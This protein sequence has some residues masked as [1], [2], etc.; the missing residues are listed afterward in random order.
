MPQRVKVNEIKN[1]YALYTKPRWEK[2]VYQKLLEKQIE[3]YCP[4]QKQTRQWSDR[5]KI[6]EEPLFKSYVFVLADEEDIP[7][8]RM[9]PGVVNFVYW[10]GKPAIVNKLDI[11]RIQRFLNEHHDIALAPMH[12]VIGQGD[13]VVIMGG[14]FMDKEAIVM[15][16]GA[17]KVELLIDSLGCKLIAWVDIEKIQR[18]R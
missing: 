1:W 6:V 18:L 11:E 14:A 17:N 2:K 8:I 15:R 12:T 16:R 3:A 7:R 4:V 10:L 9:T 5:I 13:P